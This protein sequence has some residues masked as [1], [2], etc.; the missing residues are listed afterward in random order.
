MSDVLSELFNV[1]LSNRNGL[2]GD[3]FGLPRSRGFPFSWGLPFNSGPLRGVRVG[4]S[5]ELWLLE[6]SILA[7]IQSTKLKQNI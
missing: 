7:L 2:L 5:V 3:G 4:A 6:V 1:G